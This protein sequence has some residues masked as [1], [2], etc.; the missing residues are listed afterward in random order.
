V[1]SYQHAYHAGNAADLHKHA[2]LAA[3]IELLTVKDRGVTVIETHAG[4]G[5]YDLSSAEARKTGEAAGGI[6]CADVGAGP[7]ARALGTV[8]DRHGGSTYPGSP[9]IAATLLRPQDRLV[10]MEK[11][12]GEAAA[13]RA[14]MRGTAA[15]IHERDG[16]EG[17]VATSPPTP[18]RGL[19]LIDPS[20]EVKEEYAAVAAFVPSI[21]AKWPEA[22]VLIWYPLLPGGRHRALAEALEG[23]GALRREVRFSPTR[24]GGMEGS[25]LL[26]ANPPYGAEG[27]LAAGLTQTR[28]VLTS[29]EG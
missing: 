11:H 22:A 8:R 19:V 20:Y 13:L 12:P 15:E 16:Y 7:Y 25:G 9:M 23:A 17:V 18:R 14:A 1:L 10:L 2:C 26:L 28:G 21:L 27:C 5:L 3:L 6:G 4:R 29:T 24:P